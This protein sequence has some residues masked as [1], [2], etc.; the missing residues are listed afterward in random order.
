[1]S[2]F[3]NYDEKCFICG[4][5]SEFEGLTSSIEFHSPDLDFRPSE[6][7]RG[8][9][10]LWLHKCPNCGYVAD[11]ISSPTK[12]TRD[13][14]ASESYVNCEGIHFSS[15]DTKKYYQAYMIDL[16]EGKI[17]AALSHILWAA[18]SCDDEDDVSNAILCR[19]KAIPLVNQIIKEL[20]SQQDGEVHDDNMDDDA[21]DDESDDDT[22]SL[23]E[24]I[25]LKAD[26]LRR[27]NHFQE[28]I[29]EFADYKDDSPGMAEIIGFEL[30][31]AR[32]QDNACY[33]F[34]D[35]N[36]IED[37]TEIDDSMTRNCTEE[38]FRA[39]MQEIEQDE[40]FQAFERK[41]EQYRFSDDRDP[42]ERIFDIFHGPSDDRNEGVSKE[43]NHKNDAETNKDYIED[44][45][46]EFKRLMESDP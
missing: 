39:F 11:E 1:M 4:Q 13:W 8:E 38:E 42:F 6:L 7:M 16:Y 28:L 22:P 46:A 15:E 12:V 20:Q 17:E 2:T 14:L 26:L 40:A 33:S 27:S 45:L 24:R 41:M 30:E 44:L 9:M 43:E 23:E 25:I 19:E 5:E 37:L 34:D 31:K 32:E 21:G 3:I 36:K 10:W 18:W 29:E 35:I